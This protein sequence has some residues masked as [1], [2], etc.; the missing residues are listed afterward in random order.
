MHQLLISYS[1]ILIHIKPICL[2]GSLVTNL[3]TTSRKKLILQIAGRPAKQDNVIEDTYTERPQR[4]IVS[5]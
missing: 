1:F 5:V 3:K 4:G 2:R